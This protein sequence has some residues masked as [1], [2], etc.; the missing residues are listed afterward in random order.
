MPAGD[1]EIPRL[2]RVAGRPA[3]H[4]RH[5]RKRISTGRQDRAGAEQALASYLAAQS[6]RGAVGTVSELLSLYLADRREAG[7]PGADRLAWAHKPLTAIL[8]HMAPAAIRE[9][10]TRAY[11]RKRT[12]D[13][14]RPVS[15]STAGTELQ[16]LRAALKWGYKHQ[17]IPSMPPLA[18]PRRPE[19]RD[20]WL[21]REEADRLLKSCGRPHVRLF[22]ELGL[23]TG[24]RAGAILAL[25]WERV[26]LER[27]LIDYRE[28][29]AVRTAKRRVPVPINDTL[30]AELTAAK[31]A[32][33]TEWVIEWAG[34]R[35]GSVKHAIARAAERAKLAG[36]TPHVLRHTAAT[37]MAQDGVSMWEI[38][39]ILGHS[40]P[41]MVERVYGHHSPDHLRRASKALE[42]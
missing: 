41:A 18:I 31:E 7:I 1:P 3:W 36:V 9:A 37:W 2:V 26:D 14:E 10:D 28:A 23:R 38:A 21:T 33:L 15:L 8:G 40:S 22:V 32:A 30:L 6:R 34:E 24:A 5:R 25:T 19:P 12:H 11:A 4:I 13:K 16:A 27:R 42:K 39:G 29:G 20:R 17:I 35:V